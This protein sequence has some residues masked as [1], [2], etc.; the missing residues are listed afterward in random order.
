MLLVVLS[1]ASYLLG[2]WFLFQLDERYPAL[3]SFLLTNRGGSTTFDWLTAAM[4][5]IGLLVVLL[6]SLLLEVALV[7]YDRSGLKR[8]M[9]PDASARVDLFYVALRL[10]GGI[11]LLAFV[12]S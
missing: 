11:Q 3:R 6:A 8:L 2:L 9:N 7:G 4:S 1:P 10:S 12:F 5:P